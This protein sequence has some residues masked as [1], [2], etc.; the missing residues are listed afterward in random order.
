MAPFRELSAQS[1]GTQYRTSPTAARASNQP[2]SR[3]TLQPCQDWPDPA[4]PCG[5][6]SQ[7][8]LSQII[9]CKQ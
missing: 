5:W 7:N 9:L 6:V 1:S 3:I 4:N 2:A 8:S